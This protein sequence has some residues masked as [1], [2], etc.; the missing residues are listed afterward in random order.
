MNTKN[1]YNDSAKMS[2][3]LKTDKVWIGDPCYALNDNLYDSI[4]CEEEWDEGYLA[5]SAKDRFGLVH[6]TAY[7]DGCYDGYAVDA[8]VLSVID[9]NRCDGDSMSFGEVFE[10]DDDSEH[11]VTLEYENGTFFFYVDG[12]LIETIETGDSEEDD[13]WFEDDCDD[14]SDEEDDEF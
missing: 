11:T 9:Y 2:I 14:S 5:T 3:T 12:C 4:V 1:V 8:G 7:G 6:G 10:L 13:D